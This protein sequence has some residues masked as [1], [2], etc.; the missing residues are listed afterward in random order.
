[1]CLALNVSLVSMLASKPTALATLFATLTDGTVV[2]LTQTQIVFCDTPEE[3]ATPLVV[4][5]LSLKNLFK[6]ADKLSD[7]FM[8]SLRTLVYHE[9]GYPEVGYYEGYPYARGSLVLT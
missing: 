3:V 4:R 5:S 8:L 6:L 9:V 7:G 1:M 2:P